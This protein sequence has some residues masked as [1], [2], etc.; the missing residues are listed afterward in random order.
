MSMKEEAFQENFTYATELGHARKE[1]VMNM[2][3]SGNH[4]VKK[5]G[6]NETGKAGN[7]AL[8]IAQLCPAAG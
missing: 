4:L 1:I 5:E 7:I 6:E 3:K 8:C 2:L